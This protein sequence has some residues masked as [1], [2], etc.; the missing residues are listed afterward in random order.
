MGGEYKYPIYY[1]SLLII[2]LLLSAIFWFFFFNRNSVTS[3]HSLTESDF[4]ND[5]SLHILYP[6]NPNEL[7]IDSVNNRRI[8]SNIVNIALKNNEKTI[9]QFA[10]DFKQVYE[11]P[12]WS[13]YL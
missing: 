3:N 13:Y 12:N 4:R 2:F 10:E 9:F 7:I 1:Y 8:V 11:D 6:I 5:K